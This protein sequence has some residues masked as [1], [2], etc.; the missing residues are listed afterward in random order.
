MN[1]ELQQNIWKAD[2][3]GI[4]FYC[5]NIFECS[6]INPDI[7]ELLQNE[8]LKDNEFGQIEMMPKAINENEYYGCFNLKK[9]NPSDFE[10][11]DF[12]SFKTKIEEFWNDDDWGEDLP[13][14]KKYFKEALEK[15]N[16]FD[17]TN[18]KFYY[19]NAHTTDSEKLK[20][21]NFYTYLVCAISTSRESNKVIT[22][23]FGLD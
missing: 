23:S 11:L 1:L 8:I 16:Q 15:L 21:L 17:L 13:I 18:R 9:L 7:Q 12:Y 14:F 5:L 19:I 10:A 4:G 20:D 22:M 2:A 6:Q 3:N